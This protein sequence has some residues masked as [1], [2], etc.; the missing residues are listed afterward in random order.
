MD[1]Q[2][3]LDVALATE[4]KEVAPATV[5]SLPGM[6]LKVKRPSP[7]RRGGRLKLRRCKWRG[8]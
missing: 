5:E 1:L 7:P 4:G 2:L 6:G 8:G 3:T